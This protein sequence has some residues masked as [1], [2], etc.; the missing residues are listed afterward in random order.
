MKILLNEN[1]RLL[2]V[3]W[4]KI[5]EKNL[6]ARD[7]WQSGAAYDL[8]V[9]GQSWQGMAPLQPTA[10][11]AGV[12]ELGALDGTP[13]VKEWSPV[14]YEEIAVSPEGSYVGVASFDHNVYLFDQAGKKLWD[15]KIPGGV[16]VAIN[17]SPDS[18]TMFVGES[19]SDALIYA[20]D[21]VS[22]K[23]RW[24]FA[25]AVDVGGTA[26]QRW[27]NRPK[28]TGIVVTGDRVIVS[29]EY[30]Q[31][32]V[33]NIAEKA[34]VKYVTACVIRA[35]NAKTGSPLWRYPREESMDTGVSRMSVSDDGSKL[36]FANHSWSRGQLYVDG[37]L[38]ILDGATGNLIGLHRVE[39]KGGQFSYVGI[40]DGIHMSAG[41]N[42]LA[43]VTADNR[44]MLFDISGIAADA[45]GKEAVQEFPL[46]WARQISDIQQV[47]G[48]PVYAY[49]NTAHVT[50][51]GQ[52]YFMNGATFLA[53][54]TASSGAPP[55]I[56][57][58]ATTLFAYS[59]DGALRWRWQ[60]EGGVSKLRFSKDDHYL[61]IPIY[62][63]YIIRQ[64]EK[65]GVYCLDLTRENGEPLIW[66]YSMEGV[67]VATAIA[68]NGTTIAGVEVPVRELNDKPVGQH[69]LHVLQ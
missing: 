22:G 64:H 11:V 29:A 19:S 44:G 2:S 47:G 48:V 8:R 62:Q 26:A 42:Y 30:T 32:V 56:H 59:R 21:T 35:F 46:V 28:I 39:P 57:P 41:G 69:R 15:H 20:L 4:K 58:D 12:S 66:F 24:R 9:G 61:V 17:F 49:G 34:T 53:D 1:A 14:G 52:V 16:G 68:E 18:R 5:G 7:A 43:V 13:S 36:V 6:F 40:F 50:D 31:R 54:K 37:S 27:N 55:F 65:S 45:S 38:R 23:E 60:T 63:N 33:E 67:T 51:K 10:F 25:M 3:E